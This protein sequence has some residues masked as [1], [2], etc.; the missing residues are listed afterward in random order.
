MRPG[1]LLPSAPDWIRDEGMQYWDLCP[2]MLYAKYELPA[3]AEVPAFIDLFQGYTYERYPE[4]CNVVNGQLFPPQQFLV[5]SIHAIYGRMDEDDKQEFRW[6]HRLE[7]LI[8][9]KIYH[10]AP[11][12]GLYDGIRLIQYPRNRQRQVPGYFPEEIPL[13]IPWRMIIQ[14]RL[15]GKK[16]R[17]QLL[18]RGLKV[19]IVL[20]GVM[21]RG[22]Q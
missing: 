21:A 14:L 18:G 4:D 10:Q 3:G 8:G 17:L 13:V 6:R 7:L 15:I 5:T 12:A 2:W 22:V 16:F 11:L 19:M 20:N 1:G 9:Q